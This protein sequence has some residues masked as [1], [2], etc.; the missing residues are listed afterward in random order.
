MAT[1]LFD[2]P[3]FVKNA[4]SIERLASLE[5]AFDFLDDWPL[6]K[7]GDTYEVL[8][9]ACRLAAKGIFP[10]PAVRENLRRFFIKER[11]LANMD[12]IAMFVTRTNVRSLGS[13]AS[14]QFPNQPT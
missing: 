10:L 4:R 12:E 14:D 3:L 7:R 5:E 13:R 2:K 9:R 6:E 1:T 11:I 8:L